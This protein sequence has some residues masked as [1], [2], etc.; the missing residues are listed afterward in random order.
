[1]GS[2]LLQARHKEALDKMRSFLYA[3]IYGKLSS[4]LG[5]FAFTLGPFDYRHRLDWRVVLFCLSGQ[6]SNAP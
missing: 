3:E 2:I 1:M 4:R 6:L 5:Q